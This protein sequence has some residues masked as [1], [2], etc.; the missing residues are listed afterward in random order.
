MGMLDPQDARGPLDRAAARTLRDRDAITREI[1]E[2]LYGHPQE[3]EYYA[4]E[5][6][7]C[8]LDAAE[9]PAA[10]SEVVVVSG[11]G[12]FDPEDDS[13]LPPA[14]SHGQIVA[15][16]ERSER[17]AHRIEWRPDR[18]GVAYRAT[19]DRPAGGVTLSA[20]QVAEL[21]RIA[22]V[23]EDDEWHGSDLFGELGAAVL[24]MTGGPA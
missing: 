4:I 13:V 6:R 24:R 2:L 22:S 18:D 15:M 8:P 16:V 11:V 3:R 23:A 17:F 20:E 9:N 21:R 1:A 10:G 12:S 5:V 19:L 14:A 7:V